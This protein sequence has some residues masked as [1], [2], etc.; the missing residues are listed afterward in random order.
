[1]PM[2]STMPQ[3]QKIVFLML[4][5]RS[6][7]NLLG[8]LYGG[9]INPYSYFP[10]NSGPWNGIPPGASNPA[11]DWW[12]NLNNYPVTPIDIPGLIAKGNDPTM[13]PWYDPTEEWLS[14][15][16]TGR[17]VLNQLFG[18]QNMVST[19]PSAGT[20]AGMLGFMQDYW[21][22]ES[23]GYS[24]QDILWMF[25]RQ[26]IP[27]FTAVAR[28]G[29]VSDAWFSSVPTQTNPN[30]A[31]SLTGTSLSRDMNLS[32]DAVETF[33]VPTL[34][35]GLIAAGKSCGL[36]YHD[37][38]QSDQCFTEFTFP[39]ITGSGTEIAG[40]ELFFRRLHDGT[41]PD[42]S[43][44]EPQWGWGAS[45][46]VGLHQGTDMHP[47]TSV[48][49]GDDFVGALARALINS[50][51]W[52]NTLLVITFDEHGGTYDHVPPPWGAINPDGNKSA[53]G[54][55]FNLLGAR[56]P[57]ILFSPYVPGGMVFREPTGST[58]R[59][60]HTS[61]IKTF[62]QWAGADVT[63]AGFFK[64]M[65]AAPTFEG[66]LLRDDKAVADNAAAIRSSFPAPSAPVAPP[67]KT[68][69][70]LFEG[71]AFASV[72]AILGRSRSPEEMLR[73]IETYRRDP[74]AFQRS[75]V[76]E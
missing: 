60:D 25:T 75:L 37:I 62:L 70:H 22:V 10:A 43:Y 29:A 61:F 34:F 3:I 30:R 46:S 48:T 36:Y 64:R 50:P 69:N 40:H 54:F 38:W 6:L 52:P 76:V 55:G 35:N 71:I 19:E 32:L 49:P 13:I 51:K 1:M 73:L 41:L 7:D 44:L 9:N 2:A 11:F 16:D 4:E 21:T 53:N 18:N 65:P 74:E 5:N 57:T 14:R 56:V 45:G 26:L 63:K 8:Y 47:P 58:Y 67:P 42:F 59:F 12:G 39:N 20:R 17:G 23:N 72:R 33:P 66:V 31:F 28:L 24:G 15:F 27:M 68:V